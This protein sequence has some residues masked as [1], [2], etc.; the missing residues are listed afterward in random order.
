[1]DIH[2]AETF[3]LEQLRHGLS[4]ALYYHGLHHTLDV[5]QAAL[6]IAQQ[7]GITDEE[8]LALLKTAALYHDSGFMTTYQGH[9][10]AGC[11]LAG[12]TLPGFGYTDQQIETVCSL[13]RATKVPQQPQTHLERILCDAD[14]DYLGRDDFEPIA[15]TLY[16]EL[17]VR[18]AVAD[19]TTW[20]QMQVRFL[21]N[22]TYWTPTN[23]ARRE[24]GKQANLARLRALTD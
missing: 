19:E 6:D 13:I 9:E 5:V 3:L 24:P 2:R 15:H 18:D 17:K 21:A 20:N 23:D 7:E 14:L 22:H 4:P 12:E 11:I 16:Q 1:M 10:E 8:S